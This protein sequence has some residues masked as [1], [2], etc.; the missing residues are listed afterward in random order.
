[1]AHAPP[2]VQYWGRG[3]APPDPPGIK[4]SPTHPPCFNDT[5]KMQYIFDV[6]LP[7][8][9]G[10]ERMDCYDLGDYLGGMDSCLRRNDWG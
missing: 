7:R 9:R 5:S 4:W 2:S 6:S 8:G 10:E 3:S 1:M